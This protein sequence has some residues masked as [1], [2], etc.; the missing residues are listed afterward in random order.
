MKKQLLSLL[1]LAFIGHC[2]Q[3][4]TFTVTSLANSGSGTLRDAISQ[5]NFTPGYHTINFSVTGQ[6]TLT[7]GAIDIWYPILISGPGPAL[8][9][10]SGNNSSRVFNLMGY[11]PGN[12][13]IQGLKF[14]KGS[15]L[16]GGAIKTL[17]DVGDTVH[18]I[19]C[20][21]T[22]C[23]A[24]GSGG[25]ISIGFHNMI[26]TNCAI[27][28]CTGIIGGAI[29][30]EQHTFLKI[31]N[32][33]ISN[34]TK[35]AVW[36]A[37]GATIVVEGSTL[38]NNTYAGGSGGAINASQGK[39]HVT[40]TNCTF[41]NNIADTSGGAL[42]LKAPA[43][44]TSVAIVTNCTFK[45]NS[46]PVGCSIALEAGVVDVY[47]ITVNTIYEGSG[48]LSVVSGTGTVIVTSNGSNI[49]SDGSMTAY[50]NA[51]GDLNNTSPIVATPSINTCTFMT[52]MPQSG[53]PA[54][55]AGNPVYAP[56]TDQCGSVRITGPDIGALE[57]DCAV[58]TN[59][60]TLA[61]CSSYV[62]PSGTYTWTTTGSYLDTLMNTKG[63]DSIVTISL[64]ISSVDTSVVQNGVVLIANAA[65]AAY[66]WLDCGAAMAPLS[67]ET[68]QTFTASNN[69]SYAVSVTQNG[70]TD[71][72]GCIN[73]NSVGGTLADPLHEIRIFPNPAKGKL[74]V[75][76]GTNCESLRIE[77]LNS[78]GRTVYTSD[79]VG[80]RLEIDLGIA[81]GVYQ[82]KI[83]SCGQIALKKIVI[84]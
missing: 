74:F 70:C 17:A 58:T 40:L 16:Q 6:I 69:G 28:S 55:N 27:D 9:T 22:K 39:Q 13:T 83:S 61:V 57:S 84:L 10:L 32:S 50:L 2:G 11:S 14:T 73:V 38:N 36:A 5:A 68:S 79:H 76:A 48:N 41:Y 31:R 65:G 19:N 81:P 63:C 3:A 18:I 26:I 12:S 34:C 62:S 42:I 37:V 25:A 33:V 56:S 15:S 71:T 35:G 51:N 30:K 66:Q 43:T 53:S 20:I 72:S 75:Q 8:L 52:C 46:S 1:V 47:L 23:S 54:M 80:H 49:S 78:L 45:N 21:F 7:S 29:Y 59:T 60:L 24:S 64:T 4:A 82:V 77:I 67:G 44:D